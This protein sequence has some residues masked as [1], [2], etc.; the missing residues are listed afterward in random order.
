[1]AYGMYGSDPGEY[2]ARKEER[3]D[4]NLRNLLN[5]FVQMKLMKKEE[6]KDEAQRARDFEQQMWSRGITER[7]AQLSEATGQREAERWNLQKPELGIPWEEQARRRLYLEEEAAKIGQKYAT[8]PKPDRR[9]TPAG[10][11]ERQLVSD[12]GLLETALRQYT[13]RQKNLEASYQGIMGEMQDWGIDTSTMSAQDMT[14][15]LSGKQKF[16]L[17]ELDRL[18]ATLPN[19]NSA[20]NQLREYIVPL[21]EQK[22]LTSADRRKIGEYLTKMKEVEKGRIGLDIQKPSSGQRYSPSAPSIV[23]PLTGERKVLINGKWVTVKQ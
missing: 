21:S 4:E 11:N 23:N 3:R 16:M 7:G 12:A 9:D 18:K 15:K 10:Q 5:M 14:K 20:I 13:D 2:F 22:T 19:V 1:M 17:G 6:S 8:P